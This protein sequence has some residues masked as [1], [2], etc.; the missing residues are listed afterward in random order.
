MSK[1]NL[2]RAGK[3]LVPATEQ[4]ED[5]LKRVR[6]GEVIACEFTNAIHNSRFF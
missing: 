4:D 6:T 3:V 2:I 5:L 1:V